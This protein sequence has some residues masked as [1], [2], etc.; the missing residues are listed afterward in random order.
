[1]ERVAD[2][3]GSS[4]TEGDGV[5]SGRG[6]V[7]GVTEPLPAGGPTEVIAASSI[8]RHFE[9]DA[10]GAV[11]IRRT[12]GGTD[13]IA[14]ALAAGVV[15]FSLHRAGDGG[16]SSAEWPFATRRRGEGHIVDVPAGVVL[17]NGQCLLT[18]R[19]VHTGRDICPGLPGAGGGHGDS[20]AQV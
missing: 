18:R 5:S 20:A 1:M 14:E 7:D 6:H 19:Q 12:I 16:R 2:S 4:D 15:I 17:V 9:I 8:G 11:I 13:V 3:G 10:V